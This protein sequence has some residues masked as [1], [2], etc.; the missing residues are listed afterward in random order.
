MLQFRCLGELALFDCRAL[1]QLE[2]SGIHFNQGFA[3]GI[4]GIVI[5]F[6]DLDVELKIAEDRASQPR[7]G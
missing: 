1:G 7:N 2:Q 3:R 5:K 6:D 4:R